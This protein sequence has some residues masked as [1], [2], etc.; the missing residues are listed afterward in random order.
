MP[1]KLKLCML[2][3][4][5]SALYYDWS[6]RTLTEQSFECLHCCSVAFSQFRVEFRSVSFNLAVVYF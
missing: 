3:F 6:G 1:A 4:A 5:I 2:L